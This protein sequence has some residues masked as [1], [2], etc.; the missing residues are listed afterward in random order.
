MQVTAR[1]LGELN[2]GADTASRTLVPKRI[3]A[4]TAE[5]IAQLFQYE[6][7]SGK[8]PFRVKPDSVIQL[9]AT[10]QRGFDDRGR[11]L[12][13]VSKVREIADLLLG[14]EG[15]SSPA[16][17][18][19]LVW[20]LR[21]TPS[22]ARS[23]KELEGSFAPIYEITFDA[24]RIYLT[25]SAHRHFGIVESYK[26]YLK[27]PKKFPRYSPKFEFSVEL[28]ALDTLHETAL[29]NELNSKQ[30]KI[31]SSRAQFLD[32]HT[33]TGYMKSKILAHDQDADAFFTNNIEVSA[34]ENKRHTL[35]TMSAFV[36]AIREMFGADLEELR[37]N[38]ARAD[39]AAAYFC[40][41]FYTLRDQIVVTYGDQALTKEIRPFYNLYREHIAPIE[42]REIVSDED[43]AKHEAELETAR[44]R[45]NATNKRLRDEDLTNSNTVTRALCRVARLIRNLDD[46]Q[47]VIVR[48]QTSV[49][50]PTGGR[51]FQL[52]NPE[53]ATPFPPPYTTPVLTVGEEGH[54]NIQ[55][56]TQTINQVYD[57]LCTRLNLVLVPQVKL[58][59]ASGNL[60]L[61]GSPSGLA[62]V[63]R[64]SPTPITLEV[65]FY[66][67]KRNPP[68]PDEI[69]VS[70]SPR[71]IDWKKGELKGKKRAVAADVFP[72]ASYEHD[73][74]TD[75]Q[76]W[77]AQVVVILSPFAL[78]NSDSFTG[79]FGVRVPTISGDFEEI[80]VQLA[81]QPGG[82]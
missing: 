50:A 6:S 30:K 77:T 7:F 19:T 80:S 58:R 15:V 22:F 40:E 42:D 68:S 46:W 53:V 9:D 78:T 16:F 82:E 39:E 11:A 66:T 67:T 70:F 26:R 8:H 59:T 61:T 56:Q 20:V 69:L 32:V 47:A 5:Q 21:G 18:G 17:L 2:I 3:V 27:N 55:V 14:E 31:S 33:A 23:K 57:L 1:L 71:S 48:L 12:Q 76:K 44:Q 73:Y 24:E 52:S 25:D 38:E 28:Y 49:I 13:E 41:F 62:S 54:P 4:V 75:I 35:I 51:Y 72:D 65:D 79:E 34:R 43:E 10:I 36:A 74:H 63:S 37:A 64:T 29:F 60:L 45:A 81:L